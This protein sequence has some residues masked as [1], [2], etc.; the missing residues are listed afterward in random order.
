M[1]TTTTRPAG[2]DATACPV[3]AARQLLE[4]MLARQPALFFHSVRVAEAAGRMAEGL[5]LTA[6]ATA[7]IV[8]AALLHEIGAVADPSSRSGTEHAHGSAHYFR[9]NI[10]VRSAEVAFE[11]GLPADVVSIIQFQS[12]TRY[13][14]AGTARLA[15]DPILTGAYIVAI[16][17]RMD[18]T[19]AVDRKLRRALAATM[20]NGRVA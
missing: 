7:S 9:G 19:P 12:T 5:D 13:E 8:A 16:A 3:S 20:N 14:T 15:R 6:E 18:G 2:T 1:T 4:E 10:A 11:A 17:D